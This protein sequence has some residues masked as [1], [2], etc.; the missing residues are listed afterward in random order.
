MRSSSTI[1]LR[2]KVDNNWFI[3]KLRIGKDFNKDQQK[4]IEDIFVGLHSPEYAKI[5]MDQV[6]HDGGFHDCAIA[7]FGEPGTG[8]F[9][10]VL[11]GRHVTRRCDGDSVEGAAFGGPIFYG[12]AAKGSMSRPITK[13]MSIGTRPN[14]PTN[15][16]KLWAA[17]SVKRLC[18]A[19]RPEQGNDTVKLAGKKE[20]PGL[21]F[22]DL[23]ADQKELARKVMTDLLAPFREKDRVE[24]MKLVEANGFDNLHISYYKN[25][26]IG[27]DGVW[28]VWMVEGPA[29]V[30]YFRGNPH[31]HTWV[32]H[33]GQCMS[34][35]GFSAVFVVQRLRRAGGA[36][37]IPSP[38][39]ASLS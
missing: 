24:S 6:D 30:W 27:N 26:D 28:D 29:M 3:T 14:G 11:S 16:S 19:P 20:L 39:G 36:V 34:P 10:F 8:K 38:R 5:V 2:Q 4:L 21:P 13:E 15:C 1:P 12:H 35:A 31:V 33:S 23:S 9:E 7:L 37:V 17:S 25:Q 22:S 32:E 18:S